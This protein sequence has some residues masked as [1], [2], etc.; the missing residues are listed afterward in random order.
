M[1]FSVQ[2]K[3]NYNKRGFSNYRPPVSDINITPFVDVMLVLL[4]VFMITAPLITQGVQVDLP[5]V[6]TAPIHEQKKPVQITIKLGG[7]VYIQTREIKLQDLDSRLQAIAESRK[8]PSILLRADAGVSYG[9][10]MA[11]MGS[12]QNAGLTDVGMVTQPMQLDSEK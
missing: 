12:L 2:N 4:V 10:V 9:K 3:T 11:V 6:A 7:Q 8:N 1:G 5:E